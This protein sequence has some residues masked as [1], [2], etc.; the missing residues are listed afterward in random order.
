MSGESG[1]EYSD[2]FHAAVAI[3]QVLYST[4]SNSIY[5]YEKVKVSGIT[6]VLLLCER[7][8][9]LR[10]SKDFQKVQLNCKKK[11]V[12]KRD[13]INHLQRTTSIL[14]EGTSKGGVWI[15]GEESVIKLIIGAFIIHNM[16]VS[17]HEAMLKL[18]EM[19]HVA[20]TE[21]LFI[22]LQLWAKMGPKFDLEYLPWVESQS[23]EPI[24]SPRGRKTQN[25]SASPK[26][27]RRLVNSDCKSRI[28]AQGNSFL[29]LLHFIFHFRQIFQHL[30]I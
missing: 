12:A 14:E 9:R 1:E 17:A 23:T 28:L 20:L 30:Q 4:Q 2:G 13:W 21:D 19:Q 26:I 24:S 18:V 27:R 11:P 3:E 22:Q 16:K 15:V 29:G 25:P 5:H 7:P 6:H 10:I 8:R